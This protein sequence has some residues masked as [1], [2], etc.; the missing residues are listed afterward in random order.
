MNALMYLKLCAEVKLAKFLRDEK[1]EVNIVATV[2]LIGI[3]VVLALAFKGQIEEL[4]TDLFTKIFKTTG[5]VTK[6]ANVSH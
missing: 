5:D 6:D 4:L 1:G 2:V 3:A